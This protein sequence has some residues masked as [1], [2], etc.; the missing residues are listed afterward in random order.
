M[1]CLT[2][3]FMSNIE[4]KWLKFEGEMNLPVNALI[5]LPPP[6]L[7]IL[8]TSRWPEGWDNSV[9]YILLETS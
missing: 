3:L 2:W 7:F 6:P 1:L 8:R 9:N 5:I 4:L